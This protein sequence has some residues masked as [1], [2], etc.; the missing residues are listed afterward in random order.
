LGGEMGGT[1]YNA[2]HLFEDFSLGGKYLSKKL[3]KS[4]F[5]IYLV[6]LIQDILLL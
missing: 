5:H 4:V 6:K 1:F 3:G 2:F